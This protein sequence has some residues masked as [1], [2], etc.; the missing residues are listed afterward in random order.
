MAFEYDTVL[1]YGA[2]FRA[3]VYRLGG[4]LRSLS[5]KQ[6]PPTDWGLQYLGYYTDNGA[7]YYYN[8]AP[9]LNYEQTLVSV[10]E[11]A[12]KEAIPYRFYQVNSPPSSSYAF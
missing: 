2:G 7:Y 8:P 12:A 5:G 6:A 11:Y 4:F 10:K 9:G 3:A 1:C